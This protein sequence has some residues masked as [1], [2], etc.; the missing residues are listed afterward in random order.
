MKRQL[1]PVSMGI[2]GMLLLTLT[3]LSG[4]GQNQQ[5]AQRE[6][7]NNLVVTSE[8]YCQ[9]TSRYLTFTNTSN[10]TGTL[11]DWFVVMSNMYAPIPLPDIVLGPGESINLWSGR[12]T[13]DEENYYMMRARDTW[14]VSTMPVDRFFVGK[15]VEEGPFWNRNQYMIGPKN[16][17]CPAEPF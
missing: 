3:I 8:H 6:F 9:P 1:L 4:C 7:D 11:Q 13:N 12:G 17:L 15:W 14:A 5:Q 10:V 2:L 16:E